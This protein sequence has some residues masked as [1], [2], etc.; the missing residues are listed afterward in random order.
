MTRP[1]N[2]ELRTQ[3]SVQ[4]SLDSR[5]DPVVNLRVEDVK[6]GMP[7]V[8]MEFT[9][10]QWLRMVNGLSITKPGFLTPHLERLGRKMVHRQIDV[11]REVTGQ[12]Y[13][14][15][16]AEDLVREYGATQ[17]LP[18]ETVEPR[19]TN[20]GWKIIFRSWPEVTP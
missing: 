18:G 5:D 15:E 10:G 17:A 2:A 9:A 14:R 4:S 19:N 13:D 1:D 16:E 6:S 7:L 12:T 3:I 11:P 8:D 20:T